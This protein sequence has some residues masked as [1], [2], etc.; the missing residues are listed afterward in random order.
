MKKIMLVPILFIIT[1]IFA[2]FGGKNVTLNLEVDNIAKIEVVK[3]FHGNEEYEKTFSISESDIEQFID[4]LNKI[5]YMTYSGQIK[6]MPDL[7]AYIYYEG[8]LTL[9]INECRLYK[10]TN[11]GVKRTFLKATCPYGIWEVFIKHYL[12]EG[13]LN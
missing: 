3:L 6:C 7:Q 12:P 1:F 5:E 9:I 8:G 13:S 2:C 10:V 4:E 11:N